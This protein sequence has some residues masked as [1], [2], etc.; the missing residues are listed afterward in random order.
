MIKRSLTRVLP[1]CAALAVACG[2]DGGLGPESAAPK[3]V[4]ARLEVTPNSKVLMLG[5]DW[6]L[7]VDA[8]DQF[9]EKL[10]DGYDGTWAGKATWVS[11]A[12]E[13]VQVGN[14]GTLM[15]LAPGIAT[16][17][18]SLTV[19]D[20]AVTSSATVKVD[21]PTATSVVVIA[22]NEWPDWSPTTARL[23]AGGTVTWVVPAGVQAGTI[24]LNV[25]GSNPEKLEF[26][27]GVAT[28]TFSTPGSFFYGTGL[29]FT[30]DEEGGRILVY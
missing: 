12:P 5:E 19:A 16:I 25:W 14:S 15:A 11:S 30:W 3:R 24:W 21:P 22:S 7:K 2:S 20:R 6:Q 28:R 27:N 13:I 17:T 18:A 1:L 26:V 9:G 4:P 8:W 10:L 23:K 29:G